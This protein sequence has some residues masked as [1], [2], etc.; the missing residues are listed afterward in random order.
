VAQLSSSFERKLRQLGDIRIHR[1]SSRL[2]S[3]LFG[4][5]ASGFRAGHSS[6]N[7][8]DDL[9]VAFNDQFRGVTRVKHAE[10]GF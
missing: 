2:M 1:A 8:F 9:A 5:R 7:I 10:A 3:D 6:P 4:D